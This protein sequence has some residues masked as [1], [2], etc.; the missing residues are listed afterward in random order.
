MSTSTSSGSPPVVE[1]Q[2]RSPPDKRKFAEQLV[3][4]QRQQEEQYV[5]LTQQYK[6]QQDM[7]HQQQQQELKQHYHRKMILNPNHKMQPPPGVKDGHMTVG[8]PP[9]PQGFVERHYHEAAMRKHEYEDHK[10]NISML[11]EPPP[12]ASS[13]NA[14]SARVRD[15]VRKKA[16]DNINKKTAFE[17]V[18]PTSFNVRRQDAF[19]RWAYESRAY[20]HQQP[21]LHTEDE[22][23]IP[24]RKAASEPNL[25]GRNM[26]KVRVRT[27]P[28]IENPLMQGHARHN[29]SPD[30]RYS[31]MHIEKRDAISPPYTKPIEGKVFSQ[32][33]KGGV[34]PLFQSPSLPNINIGSNRSQMHF[35]TSMS[36]LASYPNGSSPDLKAPYQPGHPKYLDMLKKQ[37]AT[38]HK[39]LEHV[40]LQHGQDPKKIDLFHSKYLSKDDNQMLSDEDR[41]KHLLESQNKLYLQLVEMFRLGSPYSS[42]SKS[43]PKLHSID[44]V[45]PPTSLIQSRSH[46]S[47]HNIKSP[48]HKDIHYKDEFL[49]PPH[50]WS[51]HRRFHFNREPY[52]LPPND[53]H[54]PKEFTQPARLRLKEHLWEKYDNSTNNAKHMSLDLHFQRLAERDQRIAEQEHKI[55]EETEEDVKKEE[56]KQMQAATE[57]KEYN[58]KDHIESM[59]ERSNPLQ[60]LNPRLNSSHSQLYGSN[61]RL[62][63]SNPH[64]IGSNPRLIGSNSKLHSSNPALHGS[65]SR[66]YSSNSKL[67]GSDSRLHGSD[68]R[69]TGSG[70]KL[71]DSDPRLLGSN[72]GSTENTSTISYPKKSTKEMTG[73][74]YDTIMLKHQCSCGGRYPDHP[75]SSGRLQSI[76][77][78]LHETGVANLC[79]RIRPR[80]ATISELQTVHSEQHTLLFGGGTGNRSSQNL[81]CFS[82]L[83]CGGVGVDADTVWNETHTSNAAR[84]AAGCVIELGFKVASGDLKNGFAI[85]RPPGHH[86]EAHQAMGFCYFNSIA[87]AAKLLCMKLA[88]ERIMIIDWDIHHGNGT[89]QMFYDDDR[90]LYLSIH[91]HDEG[92][93]FPGTGKAEECGAGIGV[94]CNINIPFSGGLEPEYGDPEYLAAFRTVVLP[95]V[96]EYKPDIILVSSGFD[97][98]S[99]HSP[100]LGGYSVTASCFAYMTKQLMEFANGK[101]V[102]ALEGGYILQ[103]LCDCAENCIRALLGGTHAQL[104]EETKQK[105]PHENAVKSLEKVAEIQGKYWAGVKRAASQLASSHNGAKKM[106]KEE[107]DTV[108]ALASLSMQGVLQG[109]PPATASAV[110]SVVKSATNDEPMDEN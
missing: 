10:N 11:D 94:G 19:N 32:G 100:Q 78:R 26:L 8:P 72:Y 88:V 14:L 9:P 109:K 56:Q 92:T 47:L 46:D 107:A 62:N 90:V 38:N 50:G 77:A 35:P 110:T 82:K 58:N 3:R 55:Q 34:P 99:G 53:M 70:S 85:V 79:E 60:T 97:A 44:N 59:E 57:Q 43:F 25:K 15:L 68:P 21:V 13:S 80:K 45:S 106:E 63:G 5:L 103:S 105:K 31:D 93:F 74:V 33:P 75:E 104:T 96:K 64:L 101:L 71:N 65:D 24:L 7:L 28:P 48:P 12:G 73:I 2:N 36:T 91:R 18:N 6:K 1:P 30:S 17:N 37:Y 108:T 54:P 81:R 61:S 51:Q 87:I 22:S 16:I 102:L 83:A 66:L 89:Q 49:H 52:P 95:V 69:L 98:A 23:L 39:F 27:K 41:V 40:M 76:W 84:M 42:I 67:Y 4:L 86:A 20:P 29:Y